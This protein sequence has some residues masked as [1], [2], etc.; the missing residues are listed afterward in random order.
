VGLLL[1]TIVSPYVHPGLLLAIACLLIAFCVV[2]GLVLL[3]HAPPVSVALFGAVV[4]GL[5]GF[6]ITAADGPRGVP[7]D[8]AGWVSIG[9][10]GGG[11]IGL[12]T[13]RGKPPSSLLW[14]VAVRC[15]VA[16][17]FGALLL[18]LLIQRACPLYVMRGA[19]YCFYD[20]DV[21]GAWAAEVT[22]FFCADVLLV[23]VLLLMSGRQAKR[24]EGIKLGEDEWSRTL[25]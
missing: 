1:R 24:R 11:V 20:V 5:F 17:P 9:L 14:H 3:R 2:G 10:V 4:L 12:V 25:I 15:L 23:V 21:L 13:T 19:G 8:V 6:F 22:F 18:L 7:A 16:L